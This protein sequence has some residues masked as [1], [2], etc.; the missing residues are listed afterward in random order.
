MVVDP[1]GRGPDA[2]GSRPLYPVVLRL[3]RQPCLV[4]GAGPVALGKI[5]GLLACGARVTVVAPDLDHRIAALAGSEP[6]SIERRPYAP[7]EAARYRLVVTATGLPEVDGAVARDAEAAGVWVNSADDAAHCTFFLPS[8]HRDGSVTVAVSTSGA[9]P[10]L[11][12][13][14]R[15]WIAA[16][17]GEGFGTLAGLLADARRRWRAEGRLGGGRDWQALF[18][19][20][21]LDLVRRGQL[22]EARALI[23]RASGPPDDPT[24][25][26]QA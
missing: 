20:P 3:D 8:V 18:D 17:I 7:G 16:D 12:S 4:V 1:T 6:L 9:S 15:R 13:W 2:V 11:A 5:E 24:A 10:A 14:L 22:D 23:D 25:V 26:E 21:I 19:G